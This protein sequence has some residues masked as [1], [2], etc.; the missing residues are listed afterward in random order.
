M[1]A[2]FDATLSWSLADLQLPMP[3]PRPPDIPFRHRLMSLGNQIVLFASVRLAF[4][5]F[6]LFLDPPQI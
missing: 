1:L 5:F 4:A 3:S 2:G 6:P